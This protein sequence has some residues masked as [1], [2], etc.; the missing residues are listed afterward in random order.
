[1]GGDHALELLDE[2]WDAKIE[3]GSEFED[4]ISDED[5][6]TVTYENVYEIRSCILLAIFKLMNRFV[7]CFIWDFY[8]SHWP[9][10]SGS[11]GTNKT[12]NNS[13]MASR[14]GVNQAL[15]F[16]QNLWDGEIEDVSGD[17]IN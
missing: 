2:L 16:L 5:E 17:E 7:D 13:N 11:L 15:E 1:L 9:K 10:N 12:R 14:L 3:D 8:E 6:D 4:K